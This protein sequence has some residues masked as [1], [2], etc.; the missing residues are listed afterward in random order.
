[1]TISGALMDVLRVTNSMGATDRS[2]ALPVNDLGVFLETVDKSRDRMS[3]PEAQGLKPQELKQAFAK[4]S[5]IADGADQ[6][7]DVKINTHAFAPPG[8][9]MS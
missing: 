4:G 3:R 6:A 2:R 5:A 8:M 7:T 1:M 9:E